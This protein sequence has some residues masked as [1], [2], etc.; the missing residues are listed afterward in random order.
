MLAARDAILRDL[1]LDL[2]EVVLG[3]LYLLPAGLRVLDRL[4]DRLDLLDVE[5]TQIPLAPEIVLEALRGLR[6]LQSLR[7]RA[8]TTT[9]GVRDLLVG[10]GVLRLLVGGLPLAQ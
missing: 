2:E 4:L 9:E 6:L 1:L 7:E 5:G 10:R 8:L 3:L